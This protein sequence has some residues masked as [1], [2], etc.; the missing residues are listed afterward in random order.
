MRGTYTGGRLTEVDFPDGRGERFAYGVDGKLASITAV[1]V[2][3]LTTRQW[4]YSWN[5]LDLVR[6]ER[7]DGTAHLMR[8]DDPANPSY[9][10]RITLRGTTG[11]ER[12]EEA[13]SYDAYGNIVQ[14][15]KGAATPEAGFQVM[16]YEYVNPWNPTERRLVDSLG[17][18]STIKYRRDAGSNIALVT[19]TTGGCPTCNS[20]PGT[21]NSYDDSDHPTRLTRVE[22]GVGA[23]TRMGYDDQGQLTSQTVASGTSFEH[24]TRWQYDPDF[25]SLPVSKEMP[26]TSGTGVRRVAWSRVGGRVVS[27]TKTGVENGAAFSL[28]TTTTYNSAGKVES[29]DPPGFGTQDVTSFTYHAD[30]G[31]LLLK[32][33]SVPGRGTTTFDYDA[34]NR[35]NRRRWVAPA[36]FGG[37]VSSEP[38]SITVLAPEPA[39]L[40]RWRRRLA[41]CSREDSCF[42]DPAVEY[43]TFFR[44]PVVRGLLRQ[45]LQRD[46][47]QYR[48]AVA[49]FH[50]GQV[51][52]AAFLEGLGGTYYLELAERLRR[53]SASPCF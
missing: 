38:V 26:S 39:E 1:G 41:E 10:T 42:D 11:S 25:P 21:T 47:Q 53:E 27:E 16:T 52:D 45:V 31:Q 6:I 5:G 23:I 50:Q 35:L 37:T 3:A 12:I 8:Y 17:Q 18:E 7:P 32:S 22:N 36:R 40:E 33:R 13:W 24:T 28:T 51:E 4:R 34:F 29:I 15:W 9:L 43:F 19:S 48:A 2:D 44:H 14:S 20:S 46:V 30:R 49:L